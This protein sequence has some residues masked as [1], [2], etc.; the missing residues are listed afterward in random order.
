MLCQLGIPHFAESI[1]GPVA[2]MA[3]IEQYLILVAIATAMVG[4][5]PWIALAEMYLQLGGVQP[6]STTSNFNTPM[7]AGGPGAHVHVPVPV[8]GATAG[9]AVSPGAMATAAPMPPGLQHAHP[10]AGYAPQAPQPQAGYAPHAPHPH[11]GYAAQAS[12]APQPGYPPQ[13]AQPSPGYPL[14]PAAPPPPAG[15]P[16]DHSQRRPGGSVA[17]P[18][19]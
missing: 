1:T 10:Q 15:P 17:P 7:G 16:V 6:G 13:A 2:D 18:G 19:L 4:P 3:G 12:H 9:I 14:Q 8:T 11:A 5:L